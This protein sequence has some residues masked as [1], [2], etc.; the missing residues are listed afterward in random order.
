MKIERLNGPK[1]ELVSKLIGHPEENGGDDPEKSRNQKGIGG[2]CR[3]QRP[4]PGKEIRNGSVESQCPELNGD[5]L[6]NHEKSKN[7]PP[8]R[9]QIT[10]GDDCRN[11]AQRQRETLGEEG[12]S[13]TLFVVHQPGSPNGK[14]ETANDKSQEFRVSRATLDDII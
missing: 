4:V 2:D 5:S 12:K 13:Y 3:C 10:G 1:E 9:P 14:W 7:P 8:L 6:K 11:K